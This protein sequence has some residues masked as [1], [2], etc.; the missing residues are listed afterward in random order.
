M[1]AFTSFRSELDEHQ[2]RRERIVKQ[3]RDITAASKKLIFSAHRITNTP[4]DK[5][6]KDVEG[7][8]KE[9][10]SMFAKLTV[11]VSGENFWRY[12]RSISPGIQEY[13]RSPPGGT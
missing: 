5:V 9:L 11:E 6:I 10:K 1:D 7:K 12:E 13:V 3:S 8:L 4:R 2:D